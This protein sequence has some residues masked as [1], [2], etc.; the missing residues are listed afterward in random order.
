MIA[1]NAKFGYRLRIRSGWFLLVLLCRGIGLNRAKPTSLSIRHSQRTMQLVNSDF[2]SE[3][4][5]GVGVAWIANLAE[6]YASLQRIGAFVD[7]ASEP[8]VFGSH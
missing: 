1:M 7:F 2:L 5:R 3:F 6:Y 4:R 8:D